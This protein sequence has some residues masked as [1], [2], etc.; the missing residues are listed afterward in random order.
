VRK[1]AMGERKLIVH[2]IPDTINIRQADS[3]SAP[4]LCELIR[5]SFSTVAERFGLNRGNCPKHPSYYTIA[6]VEQ[7]LARGVAYFI[8]ENEKRS[9]GCVAVEKASPDLCYLERLAVLPEYRHN[10][11]GKILFS[12]AVGVARKWGARK[13]GIGIIADDKGLKNWYLDL[14]FVEGETKDFSHLPFRVLLMS[15]NI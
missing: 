1:Q 6:W 12:H 4:E 7:D 5:A 9:L 13:I 11:F 3:T 2:M 10:G 8:L 14:G 15:L